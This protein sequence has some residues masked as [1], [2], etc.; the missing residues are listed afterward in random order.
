MIKR[1]KSTVWNWHFQNISVHNHN[2]HCIC[3][4]RQ[5]VGYSCAIVLLC[6]AAPAAEADSA[7]PN[8]I[9]LSME[10]V[11]LCVLHTHAW[12]LTGCI[13]T[14]VIACIHFFFFYHKNKALWATL[15][16]QT[17]SH[18]CVASASA[19]ALSFFNSSVM[20]LSSC[21]SSSSSQLDELV[22]EDFARLRLTKTHDERD[23]GNLLLWVHGLSLTSHIWSSGSKTVGGKQQSFRH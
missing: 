18:H 16:I 3:A 22:F 14:Q 7:A 19:D 9:D 12:I 23:G 1:D 2:I 8:L 6:A 20:E 11:C 21:L 17:L 10:W 13:C 5:C 4:W 15:K